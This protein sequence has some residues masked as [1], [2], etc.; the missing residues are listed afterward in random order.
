MRPVASGTVATC[1][2]LFLTSTVSP[3][4]SLSLFCKLCAPTHAL[5]HLLPPARNCA[6]L[7]TRGHS[8]Q[9]PEYST[10]LHKKSPSPWNYRRASVAGWEFSNYCDSPTAN[11][12]QTRV[13]LRLQIENS[14]KPVGILKSPTNT[15]R[16]NRCFVGGSEL[17]PSIDICCPRPNSAANPS[18]VAAAVDR[19]DRQTD[20]ELE[21]HSTV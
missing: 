5:N 4:F 3:F 2:I 14:G 6:S 8:Y 17:H 20:G 13:I 9:L 12:K 1:F 15:F 18:H 10:D 11:R 19:R 7:R 16:E 21:K